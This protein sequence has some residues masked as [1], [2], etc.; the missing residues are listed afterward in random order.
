MFGLSKMFRNKLTLCS[1]AT[2][3]VR[4][5]SNIIIPSNLKLSDVKVIEQLPK[6]SF[7]DF[8]FPLLNVPSSM[9]ILKFHQPGQ[10]TEIPAKL[11]KKVFEVAIRKDIIHNVIRYVRHQKRQPKKTKRMSEIAGSNKKPRP[12]KGGGRGQVGHRRNSVW[13]GGQKAF[14]PVLRDYS[15]QLNRKVR[16]LGTMM[17]FAAKYR[18][19][20]LI[21]FD[22]LHCETPKTSDLHKLLISHGLQDSSIMFVDSK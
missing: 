14:G 11:E 3:S 18:E 20:N 22:T 7:Q 21:I 15:I 9:N 13:R 12:Q 6:S 5:T 19:G 4:C 16:A 8:S 1:Y 17:A 2:K 10:Y